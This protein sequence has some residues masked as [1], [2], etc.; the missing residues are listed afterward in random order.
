[1]PVLDLHKLR[2]SPELLI[3]QMLLSTLH[4][5]LVGRPRIFISRCPNKTVVR[6]SIAEM[7]ILENQIVT[8][9]V[10]TIDKQISLVEDLP[11]GIINMVVMNQNIVME[12][13]EVMISVA[14]IEIQGQY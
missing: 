7:T 4:L 3:S 1:M 11:I 12:V 10:E 6:I 2:L 5:V 8:V 14:I 9:V 13:K